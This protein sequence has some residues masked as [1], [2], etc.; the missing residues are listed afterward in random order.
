MLDIDA[1]GNLIDTN[2]YFVLGTSGDP[3][4]KAP[5]SEKIQFQIPAVQKALSKG[6]ATVNGTEISITASECTAQSNLSFSF[7]L[8]ST[9]PYGQDVVAL[10]GSSNTI[11]I[12]VRPDALFDGLASFSAAV[13]TA[14]TEAIGSQH[15]G[16]EFKFTTNNA[17]KFGNALSPITGA[18]LI[19][20]NYGITPGSV[21]IPVAAADAVSFVS[22]GGQFR[23]TAFDTEIEIVVHD[24]GTDD[25]N[26]DL[27]IEVGGVL[28]TANLVDPSQFQSSKQVVLK[29]S[30]AGLDDSITVSVSNWE[31]LKTPPE[32]T[33]VR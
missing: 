10:V 30:G 2:G 20:T 12:K 22:V 33:P 31:K 8:D 23:P 19:G 24:E 29:R 21:T 27:S 1:Y 28:Y 13:N 5:G 26:I 17:A 6:A 11:S 7:S 3:R 14:I 16:G 9:L 15:P 32:P 18:Q 4:G 25:E